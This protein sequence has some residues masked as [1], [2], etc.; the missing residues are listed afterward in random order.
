MRKIIRWKW[1]ILALWAMIAALSVITLPDLGELVR[2]KGQPGIP[3]EYSSQM[4]GE[5]EKKLNE[6]SAQGEEMTMMVVFTGDREKLGPADLKNIQQAI[7]HLKDRDRELGI[8]QVLTH[9]DEKELKEQFVSK[10]G[11]TVLAALSVDR[12]KRSVQEV[13]DQVEEALGD[14]GVKHELT[15]A[16][17]I[18]EDFAQTTLDGVRK[19]EQITVIFIILVLLLV[20]RSP[21][22]PLVSLVSVAASY[23]VSLAVVAH[24][25]DRFDFP[26]ASFTQIFLVLV[27]FGIGTDYNILLFSRFKEEMGRR[28]S[29]SL[30]IVETYRTA[31]KTVIYSA[32]AVLIGFAS[33]GLAQFSIY[34]AGVAVA[35]GVLFLLLSLFTIIP[36][37]MAI[38]GKKMFW[39]ARKVGKNTENRLWTFLS[40]TSYRRPLVSLLLVLVLT[41]PVLFLYEG[42]LSYNSLEEM[43]DQSP[44]VRG[45]HIISDQFG[46]GKTM[47]ASVL[48]ESDK[49]LDSQEGL[50]FIDQ[51]TESLSRVQGVE[52]V[53][54]P[55]V[56]KGSPLKSCISTSRRNRPKKG[57]AKQAKERDRFSRGWMKLSSRS[58]RERTRIS[59]GWRNWWR[60]RNRPGSGVSRSD[61]RWNK[62][63]GVWIKGP[64]GPGRFSPA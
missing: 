24:L 47:P 38:L 35:I 61:R 13:R 40:A 49:P 46:P 7:R 2:E 12:G 11:T 5:L 62:S 37:F 51:V 21:L 1:W 15:G 44:S 39:P 27:L 16:E 28:K 6:T 25:V 48:L 14:P 4:A 59:P 8:T 53:S 55:R 50:A 45:F 9:F 17:L 33:L 58:G 34:Q 22:A 19:T 29:I 42:N 64:G 3:E 26:F 10:D 43:D 52:A 63:K 30:S 54:A 23:L 60:A 31:G 18:N 32:L 57:L 56:P 41:V 20:F 36:F